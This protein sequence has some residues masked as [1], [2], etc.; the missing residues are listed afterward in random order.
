MGLPLLGSH[1]ELRFS[2]YECDRLLT[3][4]TDQPRPAADA[5]APKEMPLWPKGAPG[6]RGDEPADKPTLTLYRPPADKA[7][8]AAVVVCPGGGYRILAV[9]HEGKDIAEWLTGQ[10]VTAFVLKY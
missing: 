10:G 5:P 7:T 6:A 9:G 8:G 1:G 2:S 3:W 4:P